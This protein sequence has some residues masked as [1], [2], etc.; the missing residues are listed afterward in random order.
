MICRQNN[1]DPAPVATIGV[2]NLGSRVKIG[3]LGEM[4]TE[5]VLFEGKTEIGNK[6]QITRDKETKIKYGTI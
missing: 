5:D 2:D 3:W 6:K 1:G 4:E